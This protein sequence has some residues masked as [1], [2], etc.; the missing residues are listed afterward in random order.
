MHEEE[1]GSVH[2]S[3]AVSDPRVEEVAVARETWLKLSLPLSSAS[4]V[5]VSVASVACCIWGDVRVLALDAGGDG[6]RV[7]AAGIIVS[8]LS[9]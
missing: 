5:P 3:V 6:K 1:E 2:P 4:V 9:L 8:L 7:V